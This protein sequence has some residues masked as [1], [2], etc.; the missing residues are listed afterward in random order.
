MRDRMG[1]V[2]LAVTLAKRRMIMACRY[3]RLAPKPFE[4]AWIRPTSIEE[5]LVKGFR[6]RDAAGLVSGGDWD[7]AV[8][9]IEDVPH[10]RQGLARWRNGLDWEATGAY[11]DML[12][13]IAERGGNH[14][15][16]ST[17]DDVVERY[18]NLD[19]VFDQVAHEGR[20]RSRSQLGGRFREHGGVQIHIGRAG[21]PIF[22]GWGG[23]H[24]IAMA[25]ALGLPSMPVQVGVA[26][27]A[28]PRRWRLLL[29]DGL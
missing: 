24:R 7:L 11:Q 6:P 10:V 14:H 1:T 20:L 5:A 17:L 27:A 21:Q 15:G 13:L 22:N 4:R 12:T 29:Q 25:L 28:A 16:C 19:A 18:R 2:A 26:H 9:P 23:C 8:R 3:G